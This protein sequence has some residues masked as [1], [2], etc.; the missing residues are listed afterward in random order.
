MQLWA[1]N[2]PGVP[3][4]FDQAKFKLEMKSTLELE[5][6]RHRYSTP[7][8]PEDPEAAEEVREGA[9]DDWGMLQG[10]GRSSRFSRQHELRGIGEVFEEEA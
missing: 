10:V 8:R 2:L 3:R 7:S 4:A 9:G 1:G 5:P 6:I